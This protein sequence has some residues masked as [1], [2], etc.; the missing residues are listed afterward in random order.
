VPR[1]RDYLEVAVEQMAL[2]ECFPDLARLCHPRALVLMAIEG[3]REAGAEPV[4]RRRGLVAVIQV[5]VLDP[6]QIVDRLRVGLE[7]AEL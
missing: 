4:A 7:R 3:C 1:R 5:L 2:D 6:A